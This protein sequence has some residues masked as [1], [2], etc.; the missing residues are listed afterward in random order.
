MFIVVR[1]AAR[2]LSPPWGP[3]GQHVSMLNAKLGGQQFQVVA[4]RDI[5]PVLRAK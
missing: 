2:M 1:L 5:P 3:L 4:A